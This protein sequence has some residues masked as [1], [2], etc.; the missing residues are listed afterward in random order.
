[1]NLLKLTIGIIIATG[2]SSVGLILIDSSHD[3]VPRF[4]GIMFFLIAGGIL[5]ASSR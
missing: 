2:F 5:F 3:L 4:I 1:M